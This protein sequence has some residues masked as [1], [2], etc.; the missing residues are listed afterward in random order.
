MLYDR[1]QR[2][3]LNNYPNTVAHDL[4]KV[5]IALKKIRREYSKTKAIKLIENTLHRIVIKM[6]KLIR[7]IQKQFN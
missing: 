5:D 2:Q 6:Y 3:I 7:Y 1:E 4:L